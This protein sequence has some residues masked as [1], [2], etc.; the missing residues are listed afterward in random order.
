[1]PNVEFDLPRLSDVRYDP[2]RLDAGDG[3]WLKR[4][5]LQTGHG[6]KKS[7]DFSGLFLFLLGG[8]SRSR[9]GLNGF[10]GRCITALLSR[11]KRTVRMP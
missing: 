2:R 11:Q 6:K 4:M 9:T 7:P 8:A 10:A 1:M 3:V 5:G